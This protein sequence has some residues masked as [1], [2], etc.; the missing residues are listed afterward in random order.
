MSCTCRHAKNKGEERCCRKKDFT[1]LG[2]GKPEQAR[3]A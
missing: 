3:K 1:R 2:F